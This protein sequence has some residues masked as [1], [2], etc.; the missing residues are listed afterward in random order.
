MMNINRDEIK[1]FSFEV[2]GIVGILIGSFL[3]SHSSKKISTKVCET[4]RT[5]E[6]PLGDNGIQ[7]RRDR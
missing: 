7:D 2:F 3:Y 4:L 1:D 5:I 6:N